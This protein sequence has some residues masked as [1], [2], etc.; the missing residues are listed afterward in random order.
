MVMEENIKEGE[1]S[2]SV[3]QSATHNVPSTA[4]ST[5]T[6]S[7]AV[8][9]C[10]E[11]IQIVS[12]SGVPVMP[13]KKKKQISTKVPLNDKL[14]KNMA[15]EIKDDLFIP[16]LKSQKGSI[17]DQNQFIYNKFTI[18]IRGKILMPMDDAIIK[19]RESLSENLDAGDNGIKLFLTVNKDLINGLYQFCINN[20]KFSFGRV[21]HDIIHSNNKKITVSKLRS[22]LKATYRRTVINPILKEKHELVSCVKSAVNALEPGEDVDALWNDDIAVSYQRLIK[23]KYRNICMMTSNK[24]YQEYSVKVKFVYYNITLEVF[25]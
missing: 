6:L 17:Q 9:K 10:F 22:V 23:K 7:S 18:K 24:E 11:E 14:F 12:E 20:R 19:L 8:D 15:I 1:S 16:P 3:K 13:R 4:G 5:S 21:C 2:I 25:H